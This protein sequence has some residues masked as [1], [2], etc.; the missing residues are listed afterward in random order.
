MITIYLRLYFNCVS[1]TAPCHL[2]ISLVW[3][4]TFQIVHIRS[5]V[6]HSRGGLLGLF[7]L[8]VIVLMWMSLTLHFDKMNF[9]PAVSYRRRPILKSSNAVLCFDST[10]INS[11]KLLDIEYIAIHRL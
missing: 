9:P 7:L 5:F 3:L 6:K 11:C 2:F 1:T 8:P 4:R 10:N